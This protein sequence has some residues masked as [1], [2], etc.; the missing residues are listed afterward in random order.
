MLHLEL[1]MDPI[2]RLTAFL[3]LVVIS[4]VSAY[5]RTRANLVGGR[6]KHP[7]FAGSRVYLLI[8][9]RLLF[10]A[11][12]ISCFV[13]PAW[14]GWAR[15]GL[16]DAVRWVGVG[17]AAV[18]VVLVWWMFHHLGN[19]VTPVADPRDDASLVTT[20]P[21]RYI[22]HPLYAFASLCLVG[23]GVALDNWAFLIFPFGAFTLMAIRVPREERLLAA[24]FGD[25]YHEYQARTGRFLPRLLR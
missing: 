2:L 23:I 3:L 8:P 21:Y 9:L 14:M 19:N 17:M 18:G 4:F 10:V 11:F 24:K 6:V 1:A 20:G 13:D 15:L 22:R 7:A 5:Y 25:A 16:P 12:L